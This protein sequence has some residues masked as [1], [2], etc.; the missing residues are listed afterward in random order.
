[1]NTQTDKNI[2]T[3]RST[4]DHNLETLD[5]TLTYDRD[6]WTEGWVTDSMSTMN[7]APLCA[8]NV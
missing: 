4:A 5:T 2:L 6:R 3:H 8:F 7:S 1:M